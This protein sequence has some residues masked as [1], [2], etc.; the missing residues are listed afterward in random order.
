M[1]A[2]QSWGYTAGN[3]YRLNKVLGSLTLGGYDASR[4]IPNDLTIPFNQQDIRDL[5][6][7]V[8]AIY[9][10][11]ADGSQRSDLLPNSIAA[12]VDSTIP[13]IYLPVEACKRFEDAFG[14]TW[15]E[16][17]QGYPVNDTLHEKL[18]QQNASVVFTLSNSTSGSGPSV[19]I[20]LPYAAFDLVM[21]Y[22]LVRN[23]TR[24]FPLARAA[25]ESQYTLGRTFLQEVYLIADYERRNFS[26]SQCSWVENAQQDIRSVLMP[27][28]V[29]S[30]AAS[31]DL[32]SSGKAGVAVGS[33]AAV[34]LVCF[35]LYFFVIRRWRIKRVRKGVE[36]SDGSGSSP[37]LNTTEKPPEIDGERHLGP[38]IDGNPLHG[39]EM[40]GNHLGQEI[41]GKAHP[42]IE[43][44]GSNQF[45]QEMAAKDVAAAEMGTKHVAATEMP[46]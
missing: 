30:S 25:N 42:G 5:T 28:N 32:S 16:K 20:T 33:V 19:D 18:T 45:A 38:E 35:L 46:A 9:T 40:D 15:N 26:I 41:D 1:I 10:M 23:T 24:Y 7:N 43:I 12:F 3:Q 44:E 13:W 29:T 17:M 31:Q 27:V 34:F 37:E 11:S 36:S 14:L 21:Q 8:N 22:P 2:S 6:V 4:F 39:Q